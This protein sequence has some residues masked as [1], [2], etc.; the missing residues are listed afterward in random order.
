MIAAGVEAALADILSP[1]V[2]LPE[3]NEE[4]DS[5]STD[6]PERQLANEWAARDP[7]AIKQ[8]DELLA[9]AGLT[10]DSVC[11]QA[12]A[13]EINNIERIDYLTTVAEARR[14]AALREI[15]RHRATLA[16][17]LR[18][19]VRDAEEAEFETVKLPKAIGPEKRI[20][21]N[22]A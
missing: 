8:V 19:T 4:E 12:F 1:L 22:A 21:K 17:M 15:D 11:A 10:M 20:S 7:T 14:N 13:S 6:Y 5:D 2:A 18:D 3:N 9:S 16:Q